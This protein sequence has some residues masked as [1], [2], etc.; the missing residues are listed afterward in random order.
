[1]L[2]DVAE[3]IIS[4]EQLKNLY[5]YLDRVA[6]S[7]VTLTNFL[8]ALGCLLVL[9]SIAPLVYVLGAQLFGENGRWVA[10][11]LSII[12][13]LWLAHEG[14]RRGFAIIA[15]LLL[16][17]VVLI[18]V[19][20]AVYSF[21][22]AFLHSWSADDTLRQALI[23][24]ELAHT[25]AWMLIFSTA[26][27]RKYRYRSLWPLILLSP[28]LILCNVIA[29]GVND[30]DVYTYI[31]CVGIVYVFLLNVLGLCL[32]YYRKIDAQHG[33]WFYGSSIVLLAALYPVMYG[34]PADHTLFSLGYPVAGLCLLG[35]GI[36]LRSN[37][38]L[39]FALLSLLAYLAYW[40]KDIDIF[41]SSYLRMAAS[42]TVTGLA[43]ILLELFWRRFKDI[44]RVRVMDILPKPV[45]DFLEYRVAEY[46]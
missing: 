32:E 17:F 33:S 46:E 6:G 5:Q 13:G 39:V 26:L 8:A 2:E 36:F 19:P 21:Q 15:K 11:L 27:L 38:L 31:F 3:G 43:A 44:F 14:R 18:T 12:V 24:W 34:M 7:G 25:A 22:E 28:S 41:I 16:F 30:Y 1:M 29:V 10:D 45:R 20:F 9:F 23:D 42:L 4:S 37:E 40:I 35:L